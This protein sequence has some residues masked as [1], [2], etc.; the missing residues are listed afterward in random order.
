MELHPP[1]GAGQAVTG[2]PPRP[3]RSRRCGAPRCRPGPGRARRCAGRWRRLTGRGPAPLRPA[4]RRPPAAAA[5]PARCCSLLVLLGAWV[6]TSRHGRGAAEQGRRAWRRSAC[7]SCS[8]ILFALDLGRLLDRR[9]GRL[10]AAARRRARAAGTPRSPAQPLL[11]LDP[12]VR[13]AIVMPICN[14]HVPTVFGGLAATIDSLRATGESAALRRLRPQ[15]HQRSRHPRRRAGGLERPRRAAGRRG[16]RRR[17]RRCA[18]TTAGASA[19]P[20]ARPATSPTS[21]AAGARAYRY[22]VV[23]DADS[24]MTG[25]CLTTLVRL[26]EAHPDAGIIQTAPRAVGHET[27]HAR[28]QQFCAA[29]LRAAVHRRHALLAA[30]RVALLGPQRDPAHGAVPARTARWRRSPGEGSLV[31]RD[32]VARLRRGGADAPRRLEGLGRR[33]ARRQLRAGAAEPAGRAAARPPLVPRQPAELAPDVRAAACTRCTAT[34]FLTGVLAYASSP[35]WLAFLLL[36]TLLFARHAGVEP[37]YF[38]EPY[39]LF[40]IWP[41]ANLQADADPVRR[42]PRCC[43]SRPRCCRCVAIVVRGEA[44]RFGGT[45][46]LLAS[47]ADRVRCTRCCWRRCGCCSTPSSCSPR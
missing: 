43:C 45:R 35:L 39:Q 11:P 12:G 8:A 7:W 22:F 21:A 13:T 47:A 16:R 3:A 42:S 5:A 9:D 31:G 41:T 24:V 26:M 34:A 17:R 20:S 40:P 18:C 25:E 38:F 46:R 2:R 6:G 14:E 29:R 44:R 30:R 32:P 19:G 27:F 4:A 23:L 10:G 1:G 36:S 28:V 37:T 15:R 33:R